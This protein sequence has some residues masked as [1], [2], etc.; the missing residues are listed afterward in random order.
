[1]ETSN[2]I[3]GSACLG[4]SRPHTAGSLAHPGKQVHLYERLGPAREETGHQPGLNA[5]DTSTGV[6]NIRS[7]GHF[8]CGYL[9]WSILL[10]LKAPPHNTPQMTKDFKPWK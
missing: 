6:L 10:V 9:S 7:H 3:R 5:E 8:S 1:M 4:Q 2:R